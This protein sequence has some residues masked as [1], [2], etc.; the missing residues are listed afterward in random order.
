MFSD[1]T[2]EAKARLCEEFNTNPGE[3]NWEV[4][5]LAVINREE[6]VEDGYN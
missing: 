3:E 5:P 1:L 4:F 2:K 6:D